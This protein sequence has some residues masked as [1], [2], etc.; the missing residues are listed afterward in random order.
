VVQDILGHGNENCMLP[1]TIE[2][3]SAKLSEKAN[4]LLFTEAE[5]KGFIHLAEECGLDASAWAP[6]SLPTFAG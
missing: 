1:G 5:V 4:G 6:E 3:N 2:A